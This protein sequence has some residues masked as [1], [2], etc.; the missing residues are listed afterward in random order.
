MTP[1]SDPPAGTAADPD[2]DP[3]EILT[4]I[5]THARCHLPPSA[6]VTVTRF[7][8]SA[9]PF[10]IHRD[11]PFHDSPDFVAALRTLIEQRGFQRVLKS[12][13]E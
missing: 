13:E 4:L 5:E 2:Q 3:D 1:S 7:P 10:A 6:E 11:H 8:G 9:F 12:P